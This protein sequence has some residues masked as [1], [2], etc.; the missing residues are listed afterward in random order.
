[1]S[2]T[3][4]ETRQTPLYPAHVAAG[5]QMVDFAGWQMPVQY[6]GLGLVEEHKATRNACGLFDVSHMGEIVVEGPGALEDVDRLVSNNIARLETGDAAYA[7]LCHADGGTVDDLYVYRLGDERFLLVVNAANTAKDYAHM[8]R[9]ALRP[10]L[11]SDRSDDFAQ[12]ALQG[13]L[14]S[15]ILAEVAPGDAIG[16]PRNKLRIHDFRGA[17]LLVATTG[18]T[19]ERGFEIYTPPEVALD[20]WNALLE[21]G[22]AHGIRPVGLGARDTLRLEVAYPLYGHELADDINGY[23]AGLGWAIKLKAADFIGRDALREIKQNKPARRLVG[24]EMLDRGIPRAGYA[25]LNLGETVGTVTSGTHSP[26][27][28]RPI[29]V[30]LVPAQLAA[31]GTEL[32]VD[33]RGQARKARVCGLPFL[34]KD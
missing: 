17:N 33:I 15:T 26:S 14:A 28:G 25:V 1:M 12:L 27:L 23:E 24:L 34:S 30:A 11:F 4:S 31:A 2:A 32:D 20:L 7:L 9:H 8:L 16:L 10:E 6:K 18:Y 5:G 3:Q 19:G 29:G 22:S 13:P 21:A